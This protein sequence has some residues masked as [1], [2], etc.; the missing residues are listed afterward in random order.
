MI[1]LATFWILLVQPVPPAGSP[2]MKEF[3]V[4]T[5]EFASV[6]DCDAAGRQWTAELADAAYA[7]QRRLRFEADRPRLAPD[8]V[9][10]TFTCVSRER[11]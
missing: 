5:V 10:I 9:T 4:D 2:E 6:D 1:L 7:P 3:S 11:N 8:G